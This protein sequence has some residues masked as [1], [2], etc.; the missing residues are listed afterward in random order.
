MTVARMK[1]EASSEA[2][3]FAR[4]WEPVESGRGLTPTLARHV[5]QIGFSEADRLRMHQ[6]AE[7]NREGKLSEAEESEFDSYVRVGD[8]VAILHSKARKALRKITGKANGHG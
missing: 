6:L 5:L 4:L 7:K 2:T 8:L 3:I 1:R